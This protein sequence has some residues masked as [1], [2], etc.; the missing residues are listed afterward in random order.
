[1]KKECGMTREEFFRLWNTR[2]DD[3]TRIEITNNIKFFSAGG[4]MFV[5]QENGN[6]VMKKIGK[7]GITLFRAMDSFRH[8]CMRNGIRYIRIEGNTRRYNFLP[9]AFP[10]IPFLK[11]EGVKGRNVFYAKVF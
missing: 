2:K 9:S 7:S 6:V 3:E 8:F 1:M 10:R 4:Y 11:D 5:V